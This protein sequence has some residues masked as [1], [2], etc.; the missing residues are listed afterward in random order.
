[1]SALWKIYF[2]NNL[3]SVDFKEACHPPGDCTEH[4]LGSDHLSQGQMI[5]P[6]QQ[7]SRGA[8]YGGYGYKTVLITLIFYVRRKS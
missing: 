6:Q 7:G 8:I 1:M 4:L 5:K 2:S 3:L